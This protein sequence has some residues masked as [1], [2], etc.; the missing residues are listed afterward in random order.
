[1]HLAHTKSAIFI[2]IHKTIQLYLPFHTR[3]SV[4]CTLQTCRQVHLLLPSC[5]TQALT[6][7]WESLWNIILNI[8]RINTS[9]QQRLPWCIQSD[10]KQ[11]DI[12]VK[13]WLRNLKRKQKSFWSLKSTCSKTPVSFSV[14][15]KHNNLFGG[16]KPKKDPMLPGNNRFTWS[17]KRSSQ[18]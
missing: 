17:E 13:G 6:A 8:S 7:T 4:L 14:Q 5:S 10:L 12:K 18:F 11:S 3:K 15:K 1:M 9:R 2:N 16:K